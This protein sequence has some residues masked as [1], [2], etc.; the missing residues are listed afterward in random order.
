MLIALTA[1]E[2]EAD[3]PGV[4]H[5]STVAPDILAVTIDQ[6]RVEYGRQ[7]PYE[8]HPADTVDRTTHTH[9]VR[10]EGQFI[11]SL[12]GKQQR[13]LFT[14]D[15]LVRGSVNAATLDALETY[16][17][18][19]GGNA[20]GIR[21]VC[22]KTKPTGIARVAEWSF[23]APLRHVVY[24][25]LERP[26][27]AGKRCTVR[28]KNGLPGRDFVY[29]P[30]EL[31]SEAV[32]VSHVGFRPDDPAKVAFLSCWMGTGGGY[33][34]REG[35]AFRVLE[36]KSGRV[37]LEGRAELSKAAQDRTEDAYKNNFNGTDVYVLD[38]SALRRPGTYRVFVDGVGCSYPFAVRED[39]W[40]RAFYVSCRGFYHQRS[41]IALGPPH[42]DFRRP[43]GFHPDDGVKVYA[44][45]TALMDTKNGLSQ[46]GS[47][48]G[49]LVE[50]RTDRVVPN[51]WGGY[52]DAGDW[53]RRIQHLVVS[54]YL[55]ELA[56]LHEGYFRELKLNIPESGN[57]L[58]DVV[59][60]AL[61]NLDCYRRMQTKDGGIRGGIESEEHPRQGEGSWQESLAIMAYAPGVWSSYV[62]AGTAARASLC[63]ERYDRKLAGTYR[64]SA[65]RAME[66][67]ERELPEREGK[68][69]PHA[70]HDSRNLASA[71]LFRLTGDKRWHDVFL[72]TSFLKKPGTPLYQWNSH[73]QRD[74]AW[75][76]ARTRQPGMDEGV[77]RNCI[78]AIQAEA[79]DRV[80]WCYK[81]GFRWTKDPWRPLGWG[82][83]T[84]P[85]T[86]SLVRAH[87]LTG[88]EKYLKAIVLAC[89]TGTGANPVNICYTTGLGHD[90]PR[91]PLHVDSRVMRCPPPPGLTVFGPVDVKRE[92]KRKYYIL[93]KHNF[94]HPSPY[95]WPSLE[96]FWD[97]FWYP[98]MCE[99]TVQS[100]MAITAYTWGYL[101][102]RK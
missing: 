30:A 1:R 71:E 74:A 63:L 20:V 13:T 59:D 92:Q 51:A 100:P 9:W 62:Y 33:P 35:M 27:V 49:N 36:H 85:D 87:A 37:V 48:F 58:P 84:S 21:A 12:V 93:E 31:R 15:R 95:Q 98:S 17:V 57:A 18:T 24:L 88:D 3:A 41:G 75:V 5:L 61:F 66:W 34:Y 73:E 70:V 102:A 81:T 68:S 89:G 96:A 46:E 40:R 101:A 72:A 22:R 76:Y 6:G 53:D 67:A 23:Q 47:N 4:T 80:T 2:A 90:W 28:F 50:G 82:A 78:Q 44:S 94:W 26:L 52:M 32:H 99:Y 55:L 19:C 97:V 79:N 25:E 54:N 11:G 29:K 86:L 14:P 8:P 65:I 83:A 60:E 42:T 77:Q 91:S 45:T 7:V 69:D 16:S 39:T 43:R 38:F 56:L 64:E 10:R